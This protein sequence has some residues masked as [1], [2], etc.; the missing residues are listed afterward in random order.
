[1]MVWYE[2]IWLRYV[3]ERAK[4][5]GFQ[6]F[7]MVMDAF[8]AHFTDNV[9]AIFTGHTGFVKVPARCTSKVQPLD[10]CIN[11]LFKS[12]LRESWEDHAVKVVKDTGDEASN[13]PSF[14][15]SYPTRQEIVN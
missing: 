6:N 8:K 11:K 3:R 2:K 9:A 10:I 4:E 7:L 5:I 1:M 12:I 13:N 14:K 15:L